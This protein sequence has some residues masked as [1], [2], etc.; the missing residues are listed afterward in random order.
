MVL[1]ISAEKNTSVKVQTTVTSL[2]PFGKTPKTKKIVM[3][4]ACVIVAASGNEMEI[5]NGDRERQL[6]VCACLT[7]FCKYLFKSSAQKP[8][9][10]LL[11]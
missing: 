11:T 5:R 10:H 1:S 2:L 4:A 9:E 7:P 3:T 8:E 6:C